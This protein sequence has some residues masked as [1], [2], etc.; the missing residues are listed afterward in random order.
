[1]MDYSIFVSHKANLFFTY[2]I[3][4][5]NG[6]IPNNTITAH[7]VIIVAIRQI[8]GS[9]IAGGFILFIYPLIIIRIDMMSINDIDTNIS[10]YK[11][12]LILTDI[13]PGKYNT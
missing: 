4:M 7:L 6:K 11:L 1:M 5:I 9:P 8:M 13:F 10:G 2:I 12:I 3:Y